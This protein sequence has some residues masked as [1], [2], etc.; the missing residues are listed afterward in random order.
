MPVQ[1]LVLIQQ[2]PELPLAAA[3]E[4]HWCS[5]CPESCI[6]MLQNHT[7]PAIQ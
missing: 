7:H 5:S 4:T 2:C 3:L 6:C 1:L